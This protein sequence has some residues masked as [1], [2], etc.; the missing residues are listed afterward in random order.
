ME[1]IR[2]IHTA[3]IKVGQLIRSSTPINGNGTVWKQLTAQAESERAVLCTHLDSKPML[4][5]MRRL[6]AATFRQMAESAIPEATQQA[7]EFRKQRRRKGSPRATIPRLF[8]PR[9]ATALLH[10]RHRPRSKCGTSLLR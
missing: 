1:E 9:R 6:Y 7:E 4:T 8:K 3:L 2:L 10:K 5:A